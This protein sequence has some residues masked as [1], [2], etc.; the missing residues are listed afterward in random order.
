MEEKSTPV[1]LEWEK[2][3]ERPQRIPDYLVS[4]YA[5]QKTLQIK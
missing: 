5:I 2:L 1:R 4:L 3:K